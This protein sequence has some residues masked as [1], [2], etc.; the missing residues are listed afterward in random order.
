MLS[1]L[2]MDLAAYLALT[3]CLLSLPS[4][5]QLRGPSQRRQR[6]C[7]RRLCHLGVVRRSSGGSAVQAPC[8]AQVAGPVSRRVHARPEPQTEA[9]PRTGATRPGAR[10]PRLRKRPLLLCIGC[11]T[12]SL[13]RSVSSHVE[14]VQKQ[15]SATCPLRHAAVRVPRFGDQAADS[16]FG[17]CAP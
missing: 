3:D 7:C 17:V 11:R 10:S 2:L 15:P 13:V 16:L 1:H 6:C 14:A 9:E 12:L 5:G 8:R 4:A